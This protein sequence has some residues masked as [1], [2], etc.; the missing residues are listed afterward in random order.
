MLSGNYAYADGDPINNA[1]PTGYFPWKRTRDRVSCVVS[2][3]AGYC[4]Y[5]VNRLCHPLLPPTAR[6]A[7]VAY[8]C[9]RYVSPCNTYCRRIGR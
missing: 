4:M 2:C 9:G 7:C 1:D 8:L 3:V 5:N 6:L